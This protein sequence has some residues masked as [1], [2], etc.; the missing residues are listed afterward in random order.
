FCVTLV[1]KD[2]FLQL[3]AEKI[4]RQLFAGWCS[5]FYLVIYAIL[6]IRKTGFCYDFIDKGCVECN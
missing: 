3:N 6:Y 5:F 2:A 1:A 4:F